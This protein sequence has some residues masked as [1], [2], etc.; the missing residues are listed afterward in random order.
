MLEHLGSQRIGKRMAHRIEGFA[1]TAGEKFDGAVDFVGSK[2]H[3]VK[4]SVNEFG[5]NLWH[6][7]ESG[8]IPYRSLLIGFGTGLCCG[9]FLRRRRR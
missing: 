9:M 3:A 1:A 8:D 6:K 4:T 7:V 5:S 2:S